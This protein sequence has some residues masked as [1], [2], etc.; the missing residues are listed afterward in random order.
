MRRE[1]S[2]QLTVCQSLS[3]VTKKSRG[4]MASSTDKLGELQGLC[5][6]AGWPAPGGAS[7]QDVQV[8]CQ[9]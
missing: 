4:K 8:L 5:W 2:F 6:L 9:K 3:S 1:D 7:H